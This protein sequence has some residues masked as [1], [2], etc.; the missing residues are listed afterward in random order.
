[1][2]YNSTMEK[3][4]GRSLSIPA[5]E[6]RRKTIVRMKKAQH[7]YK[8]I[9][10]ATGASHFAI[11][12]VWKKYLA[13]GA[14]ALSEQH[15]G[16]KFGQSR[17]L[18]PDQERKI[19]RSIIDKCPDQLKMD[20]ALWTRQAVR[21][22]VMQEFQID[23]PIRTMGEY[24]KRWGFTP[25]KPKKFAYERS[26]A[27]VKLWLDETYP[28]IAKRAK[29][30]DADIYWGDETGV[31]A[32]DVRGRGFSPQGQTPVVKAT[33]KYENLSMV[34]AITNQGKV[35]WM[36]VDGS[37]NCEKFIDFLKRL[38]IGASRK[39]FLIL[40][41]LRVH[42]SE[43]VKEW[44]AANSKKIE[45]FFLPSYSPDLNPDEHV[46][47]DLKFGVGSKATVRT[48]DKLHDLI[49]FHMTTLFTEPE[50]IMRYFQ[51]PAISYAG[52]AQ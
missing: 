38:T 28:A 30:E 6:E 29:A 51:D 18:N 15:H 19:Q 9:A 34:S 27:K 33:A 49:D 42:H 31:R 10:R 3:E 50:R 41:N 48:K 1:M 16:L 52:L 36:I 7:S 23:L 8:E 44:V 14:K 13:N 25:Q 37:I 35:E 32:S 47:A 11:C 5:R 39:I 24:L 22:L 21:Q 43:L 2:C 26:D 17:R 4:D 46:N 12:T 40:D 45:L 20:F